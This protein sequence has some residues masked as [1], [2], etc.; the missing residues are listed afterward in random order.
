M[1]ATVFTQRPPDRCVRA[2]G[3]R[4]QLRPLAGH[5]VLVT[6]GELHARIFDRIDAQREPVE[7]HQRGLA[8]HHL[9]GAP[10]SHTGAFV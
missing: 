2:L 3:A 7:E 1:E 5:G 8:G 6:R 9:N 10:C 4:R